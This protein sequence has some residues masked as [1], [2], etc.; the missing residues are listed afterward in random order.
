MKNT[1][2]KITGATIAIKKEGNVLSVF[3]NGKAGS[4]LHAAT[5]LYNFGCFETFP[6]YVDA[7]STSM[8]YKTPIRTMA[9]GL[10]AF[11]RNF[12]WKDNSGKITL[13][14]RCERNRKA[15]FSSA[16]LIIDWIALG[17]QVPA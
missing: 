17:R 14:N 8:M 16:H 7:E 1:I 15:I 3:V 10:M 4:V 11:I 2:E 9:K 13:A 6:E 12:I 5:L